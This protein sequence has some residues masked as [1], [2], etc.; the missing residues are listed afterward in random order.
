MAYDTFL[1]IPWEWARRRARWRQALFDSMQACRIRMARTYLARLRTLRCRGALIVCISLLMILAPLL[2]ILTPSAHA[3]ATTSHGNA[4]H[5]AIASSGHR[6]APSDD[7]SITPV[8]SYH[9]GSSCC[10]AGGDPSEDS[11]SVH[12]SCSAACCSGVMIAC[13]QYSGMLVPAE[14]GPPIAIP[15]SANRGAIHPPPRSDRMS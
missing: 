8:T 3:F 13:L 5:G 4:K 10:A 7:S 12:D 15:T 11:G 6:A 14:T 1:T 9:H 2:M